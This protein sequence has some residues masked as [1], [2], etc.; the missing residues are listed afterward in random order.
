MSDEFVEARQNGAFAAMKIY[1]LD[2]NEGIV[3]AWKK[4]FE[5]EKN[6]LA[7]QGDFARFLHAHPEID[8]IVSPANSFGY[9]DGGYDAAITAYFGE[10]LGEKVRDYIDAHCYGE[11]A[12]GTAIAVTIP[13]TEKKLLHVPTMRLPSPIREPLLIYQC[14]RSTLIKA[15]EEGIRAIVIPA[16]GGATGMVR[17]GTLAKYMKAGYAQVSDYLRR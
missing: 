2:R 5:G 11:Q 17:A 7:V 6:V 9:M 10:E 15:L 1:L 8:G 14:M 16:F 12:L 3:E 13:G 4:E